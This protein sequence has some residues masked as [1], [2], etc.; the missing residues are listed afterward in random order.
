M[1]ECHYKIIIRLF[2][3]STK[4]CFCAHTSNFFLC[5]TH[6]SGTP[7]PFHLIAVHCVPAYATARQESNTLQQQIAI[8]NLGIK[9]NFCQ[10]ELPLQNP[11]RLPAGSSYPLHTW[12]P[13]HS[14]AHRSA[15]PTLLH[16]FGIPSHRGPTRYTRSAA[17]SKGRKD[18]S[19]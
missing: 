2:L 19:A 7:A 17:N 13:H 12:P 9:K 15:T 18:E 16:P 1:L 14:G 4:V 6:R 3:V 5:D 10:S 8:S 11:F